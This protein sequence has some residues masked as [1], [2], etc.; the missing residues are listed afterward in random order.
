MKTKSYPVILLEKEDLEFVFKGN[1]K[2]M[3]IIKKLSDVDMR[4]I[5]EDISDAVFANGYWWIVE[6]VFRE[7]FLK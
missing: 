3:K 2:A 4:R 1:K 6:D 7:R 5:A